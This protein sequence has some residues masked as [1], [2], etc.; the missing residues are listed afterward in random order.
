MVSPSYP[1]EAIKEAK[2]GRA[3][4]CFLVDASGA[5]RDPELLEL[6][7]PI[8]ATPTLQAIERSR[9]RPA[10]RS[11]VMRPGCRHYLYELRA[12]D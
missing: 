6:S 7:D 5:V 8:F 10:T 2:E 9:Y 3:I 4:V 1:R 11:D 12:S